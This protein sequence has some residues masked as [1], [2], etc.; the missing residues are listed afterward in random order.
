ME[1][2]KHITCWRET[3]CKTG[4]F[5]SHQQLVPMPNIFFKENKKNASYEIFFN[6]EEN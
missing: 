5:R 3:L 4:L 1:E 2:S 6:V